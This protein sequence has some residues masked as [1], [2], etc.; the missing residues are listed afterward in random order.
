MIKGVGVDIEAVGRIEKVLNTRG[1]RF[2]ERV[3]TEKE[4]AY[5]LGMARP[6][7]HLAGRFAAKEAVKK[8]AG[9]GSRWTDIE[10][11]ND[12]NRK[13]VVRLKNKGEG[14]V[15]NL[16]ISHSDDYA[17]AFATVEEKFKL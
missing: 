16:S 3:F 2:L 10:V 12:E 7:V 6:A 9:A 1:K 8:A 4:A 11:I 17:V 13:P 14:V 15:I 5:C